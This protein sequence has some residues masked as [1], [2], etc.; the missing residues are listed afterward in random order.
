MYGKLRPRCPRYVSRILQFLEKPCSTVYLNGNLIALS[1]AH[2]ALKYL[3]HDADV[4]Y[5]NLFRRGELLRNGI[6]SILRERGHQV[7][8]A[9]EGPVFHLSFISRRPRNYREL[10][11]ADTQKYHSF[12]LA[13]LDEGVLP[14]PDGR[15]Y[16]STAH[17]DAD[18]ESTL[19]AVE[20]AAQ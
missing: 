7:C 17:T 12:L 11:D 4:I 1:A 18:I 2:A 13:L 3:I 16:V 15:W 10:L 8:A 19:K 9:G 6:T 5:R 14:L 20:R